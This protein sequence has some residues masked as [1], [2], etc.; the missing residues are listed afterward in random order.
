MVQEENIAKMGIVL[1]FLSLSTLNIVELQSTHIVCS[2][3]R[4]IR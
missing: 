1:S 3:N 4:P 2:P